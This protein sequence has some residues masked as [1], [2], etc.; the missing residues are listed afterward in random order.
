MQA[1][2]IRRVLEEISKNHPPAEKL[3]QAHADKLSMLRTFIEQKNLVALPPADTLRVEPEPEYKRG[4]SGAEYLAP[5]MLDT[6]SD[7]H[8]TFYVDPVDPSWPPE[9]VESYLRANNTYSAS[10]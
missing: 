1:Q 4:A 8:G 2:V 6:T 3:V 9:K 5:G 7:W 10:P